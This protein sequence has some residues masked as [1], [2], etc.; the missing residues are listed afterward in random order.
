MEGKGMWG[1]DRALQGSSLYNDFFG[2]NLLG[3][4]W[5]GFGDWGA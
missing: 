5:S 4:S 2:L 1:Q 3:P